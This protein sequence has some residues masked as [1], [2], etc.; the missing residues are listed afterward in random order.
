VSSGPASVQGDDPWKWKKVR[1]VPEADFVI[2]CQAAI[3]QGNLIS[4][5]GGPVDTLE[6]DHVPAQVPLA[7]VARL[8]W[9]VG[10]MDRE[11]R[12]EI[13][14]LGEDGERLMSAEFLV[15]PERPP[16]LPLGWKAGSNL[17]LTLPVPVPRFGLYSFEVIVDDKSLKTLP[18]RAKPRV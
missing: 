3:P 9:T 12:G 13:L 7:V 17:V 14:Y 5:L 8:L 15:R 10:E 18:F 16:D 2:L 1:A 11:H 6:I 4:L